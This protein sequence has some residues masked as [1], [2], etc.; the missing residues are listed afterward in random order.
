[1]GIADSQPA[2]DGGAEKVKRKWAFSNPVTA[3]RQ[4]LMYYVD[5]F[6]FLENTER[7]WERI[8]AGRCNSP[9]G[10]LELPFS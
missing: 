3:V 6:A 10:Q 8:N 9:T 4:M 1:M 5:I 7:T 2:A